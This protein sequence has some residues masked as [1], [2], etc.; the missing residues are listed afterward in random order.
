MPDE[1]KPIRVLPV[2]MPDWDQN[3]EPDLR[4]KQ[5][6]YEC[7]TCR[8]N[9]TQRELESARSVTLT[10]DGTDTVTG[11]NHEWL[12]ER[13][14]DS[15]GSSGLVSGKRYHALTSSSHVQEEAGSPTA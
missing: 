7:P 8:G 6:I 10:G 5:V 4:R 2:V 13:P 9:G 14:C 11:G 1:Q 12:I 15:C 3:A